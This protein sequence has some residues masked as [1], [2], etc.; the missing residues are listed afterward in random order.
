MTLA[1][2]PADPT[3]D[4]VLTVE[5]VSA[6]YG[7][8]QVLFDV[9]LDVRAGEIVALMGSNGAGKT[10]TLRTIT[11]LL[12]AARGRIRLEGHDVTGAP[13]ETLA[14]RGMSLVPEGRGMLRDLTVAENLEL[15]AYAVRDRAQ[16]TA[17]AE[18]AYETFPILAERRDVRAGRLSGGQQQMLAIAR[19]LMSGP[20]VLLVDEASLGLSPIM[21]EMVFELVADVRR[22]TGAAVL[23]VEQNVA[24]LDLADRAFVLEKG[25]VVDRAEGPAVRSMQGR[26]RDAYLGRP[27]A[28]TGGAGGPQEEHS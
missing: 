1:A 7:P 23:M 5:G 17:A 25:R 18:R 4:P 11:G 22:E 26:L 16:G 24:A 3:I 2:P 9:T 6:G 28:P 13:T 19:A 14:H 20:R 27:S 21:T 15:G 8:L 12:R 10:T